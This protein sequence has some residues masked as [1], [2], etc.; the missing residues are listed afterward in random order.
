MSHSHTNNRK[1]N[2][3][4][5]RCLRII[6][7]DKQSSFNELL[8]RGSSVS[9][10]IRKIQRFAI[11]MLQGLSPTIIDNL[12]KLKIE[13]S[14]NLRQVSVFSRPTVKTVYHGTKSILYL[15]PK[16]WN[17]LTEKLRNVQNLEKRKRRLIPGRLPN[18]CP[19]R[20]CF[21]RRHR[22]SLKTTDMGNKK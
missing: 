6:Y 20:L 10:H 12:F 21:H 18:N 8:N 3:L 9:V 4:C 5:E 1:I 15:G 7:N 16:I 19:C 2:V 22:I 14:Y 17:I 13:N 11:E